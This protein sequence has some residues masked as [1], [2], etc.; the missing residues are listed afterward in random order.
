M[1]TCTALW[2]MCVLYEDMSGEAETRT[3]PSRPG[4]SKETS[5]LRRGRGDDGWAGCNGGGCAVG[6]PR[7]KRALSCPPE[8]PAAWV[9]DAPAPGGGE[10]GGGDCGK[11]MHVGNSAFCHQ[12]MGLWKMASAQYDQSSVDQDVMW[13]RLV[14]H[15]LSA[16]LELPEFLNHAVPFLSFTVSLLWL[17]L[18]LFFCDVCECRKDRI[19][20][21]FLSCVWIPPPKHTHRHTLLPYHSALYHMAVG[22]GDVMHS[23]RQYSCGEWEMHLL[24]VRGLN[25]SCGLTAA[26]LFSSRKIHNA[27][28][29]TAAKVF[30]L[31]RWPHLKWPSALSVL[32]PLMPRSLD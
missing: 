28:A 3:V 11:W 30:T 25:R 1:D 12:T 4:W 17:L 5:D 7:A 8:R 31:L 22:S 23:N 26:P 29:L 6:A 10:G 27:A 14:S 16:S 21:C 24:W 18:L 2:Y 19:C 15:S 13:L 20:F 32:D 9:I